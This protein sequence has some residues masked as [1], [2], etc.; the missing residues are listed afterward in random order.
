MQSSI[1]GKNWN[2]RNLK[3]E[4]AIQLYWLI[5]CTF[6]SLRWSDGNFK[7][8]AMKAVTLQKGKNTILIVFMGPK[9]NIISVFQQIIKKT[10]L[11]IWKSFI[12]KKSLFKKLVSKKSLFKN[13][14]INCLITKSSPNNS[15]KTF[16]NAKKRT[17]IKGFAKV[18]LLKK[19]LFLVLINAVNFP[20]S[21]PWIFTAKIFFTAMNSLLVSQ[22]NQEVLIDFLGHNYSA[23]VA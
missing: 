14:V 17:E 10:Q 20:I 9:W 8:T 1:K 19:P 5:H 12:F 22:C 11:L 23:Q 7:I 13:Q 2:I 21:L 6:F 15:K 3:K 18:F 4:W 16:K